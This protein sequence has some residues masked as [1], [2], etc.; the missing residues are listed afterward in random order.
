MGYNPGSTG[1]EEGFSVTGIYRS[2]WDKVER[3]PNTSVLNVEGNMNRYFPGGLGVNFYHDQIG[4][5]KQNNFMLNYSY[6][7]ALGRNILGIGVGLGF[8]S[9]GMKP[10]FITPDGKDKQDKYIP[11]E[12]FNSTGFDM[13]LGLYF[14]SELGFYIGASTTHLNSA[15]LTNKKSSLQSYTVARHFYLMGGYKTKPIGPGVIDLQMMMRTDLKKYSL[16]ANARY[17]FDEFGYAGLIYRT[18]DAVAIML[19][20]YPVKNLTIG[21]SY[22]LTVS[23]LSSV[24]RGSHEV[25]VIYSYYLPSLPVTVS[26]NPRW[27]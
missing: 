25:L 15:T 13:N 20:V 19:G 22:D 18:S 2:Q 21:Y 23:K 5:N 17:I 26:R 9:F 10:D 6:P 27:L 7:L 3:A 11:F 4:F 14:K 12:G 8:E 24:S 16:D 1:I